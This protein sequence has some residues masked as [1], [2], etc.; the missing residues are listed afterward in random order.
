MVPVVSGAG[1]LVGVLSEADVVRDA[2][3]PDVRTHL[4][5]S[6][7]FQTQRAHDVA[8]LMSHHPV[9]VGPDDDLAAAAVLMTD[10]AVK[11]LPV[12][13]HD[14]RVVGVVS[15]R[16]IVRV[17]A[18]SDQVISAELDELF[19]RLGTDWLVDVDAGD[20][21]VT[22]PVGD[23]ETAMAKSSAYSV[24]GVRSVSVE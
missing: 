5:P 10:T 24:A 1:V 21:T 13:N 8:D 14:H 4:I 17:L 18:R 9:T 6:G 16:D 19:R 23:A 11:S 3:P 15:R 22:G 7:N 2:L 20:V 12:V